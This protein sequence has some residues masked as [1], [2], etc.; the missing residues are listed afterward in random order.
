MTRIM[1]R[2]SKTL[3]DRINLRLKETGLSVRKAS[4]L[5]TGADS[6]IRKILSGA[7]GNP[8]T[9]TI[10]KI[11]DVLGTTH[12]WMMFG[13]GTKLASGDDSKVE[14]APNVVIPSQDPSLPEIPVMGT[15]AGS[16]LETG[17]SIGA[18]GF[19]MNPEPIQY[20]RRPASLANQKDIYAIFVRGESMDP[21]HPPGDIRFVSPNRPCAPGDSVI[22]QT[23]HWDGDP[24]QAYIKIY[25]RRSGDK[26]FLEQLNPSLTIEIPTKFVISVHRVVT[27]N[28]L[29]GL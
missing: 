8:R 21:M 17:G 2:M 16:I 6:T 27:N 28:E 18:E 7:T 19:L 15:A 11:A 24:G 26:I 13:S 22:V 20:V 14:L 4:L 29:F 3:H 5:A 23:K 1:L 25:R 9:D 10:N 12:E